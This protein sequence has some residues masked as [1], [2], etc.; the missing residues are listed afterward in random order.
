MGPIICEYD[1]ILA[2]SAEN[3]IRLSRYDTIAS[4]DKR[5]TFRYGEY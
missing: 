5:C 3:W 1:T 4:G 2:S